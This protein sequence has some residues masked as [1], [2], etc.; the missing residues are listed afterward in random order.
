MKHIR[1]RSFITLLLI[2]IGQTTLSAADYTTYLTTQRGFTEVTTNTMLAGNNHFCYI[3]VPAEDPGLIVGVGK[4][5]AKPD[6]ASEET[7]ALRYRSA[8]ED[9]V[10][11]LSN[12]FTIEKYGG[13]IG[14]RNMVY[15][16]DLFQTHDNAGY[17]YV[18][19]FTDK[20]L[21]E[22]SALTPIR[23]D[24][25]WLFE[26][27]KYPMSSND[28]ACGYLGPWNKTVAEGE[29]IALNRRN[30]EGDEAGHY[31]VFRIPRVDLMALQLYEN[32]LTQANGFKE[33][34]TEA[35]MVVDDDYCYLLTS[36]E[37]KGFYAGVG[38]YEDKCYRSAI[39]DP[40]RDLSSFFTIEKNDQN[41]MDLRN[42]AHYRE[43]F[44]THED[45]GQLYESF[46]HYRLFRIRRAKLRAI[47]EQHCS[48]ASDIAPLNTS[49]VIVNPSFEKGN[50]TGWTLNGKE[51]NN[52]AFGVFE[53]VM[54]GREGTYLMNAAQWWTES[55]GISQRVE[56]I[57]SGIYELSATVA[58]YVGRKVTLTANATSAQVTGI[59]ENRGIPISLTVTVGNDQQLAVKA[60]STTKWGGENG[61]ENDGQCFF[62]IDNVCLSCKKAFLGSIALQLPNDDSTPLRQGQWYYYDADYPTEHLLVGQ[63]D[64]LVY[65]TDAEKPI[66]EVTEQPAQKKV[67]ITG[68]RVF[69][70][71]KKTGITLRLIPERLLKQ[72]SFTVT[73]LNVDGLPNKIATYVLNEDGPGSDG[74]KLISR[75]LAEKGYDMIG[76]SEDFNYHG[77]LMESL[78]GSYSSG[79]VRAKLSAE[80]LPWL[81]MIQGRFRFDTDGLNLIWK[82]STVSATN[83][84]WTQWRDMESTDGNQYVKK[85]FRHY[86]VSIGGGPVIDVYVL[87]MDAGDTNASWSRESQWRQ[88]ADAI[89]ESDHTRS[90]LIIGDTNSRWT[91]EDISGNFNLRLSRDFSVGDVW[92]EFYQNGCYPVAGSPHF[93][94]QTDRSNYSNYEVVDKILYVNSTGANSVQLVPKSF[95]IEQD[96]TYGHVEGTDNTKPLG[97]HPPVVVTF[98]YTCAGDINP[99]ALSI[100]MPNR[101]NDIDTAPRYY[102]TLDGRRLSTRPSK[103]GL[104]I[105]G[106]RKIVV[107]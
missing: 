91:R 93:V 28:W 99:Q 96:Y 53:Y 5:E 75:Y 32:I 71:A 37:E 40:L 60:S 59:G 107:K 7:R 88:L 52:G 56:N 103:P 23:Q 100:E 31:R 26:S 34:K 82:N 84:S 16:T 90:K 33:V 10:K 98:G 55:L 94:N 61:N 106:G 21:D 4:Y 15:N 87:H 74:T 46:R 83:E 6:W 9:P 17:M 62:K 30:T 68:K 72:G 65:T 27:G 13:K 67:T 89:N 50:A 47:H 25:Y 22:W 81:E 57:P 49:W 11:D 45:A 95:R 97:D 41:Q 24:G 73:A 86:D 1:I 63:T 79:T 35:D 77:S 92:V 20:M 43:L 70:K 39:Y 12:F 78:N 69:F 29:P 14:L 76:A 51:Q 8:N 18:N 2:L 80:N 38:R 58:S 66:E 85:G 42:V 64:G 54:S 104:Y 44:Q 19:T 48:A 3:M 105:Y 36:A 101:Q 102:Y